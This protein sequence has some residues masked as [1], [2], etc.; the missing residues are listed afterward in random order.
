MPLEINVFL[1]LSAI[2]SRVPLTHSIKTNIPKHVTLVIKLKI[3]TART[4]A[5]ILC[6]KFFTIIATLNA[7]K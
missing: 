1:S 3:V 6:I 7:W 4:M 2:C 5:C